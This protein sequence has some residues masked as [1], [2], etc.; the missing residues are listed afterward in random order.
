MSTT[1]VI[2]LICVF[3]LA[4]AVCWRFLNPVSVFHMLDHPNQRSLHKDPVPRSGGLAFVFVAFIGAI[5]LALTAEL[6]I[7]LSLYWVAGGVFL[8][9]VLGFLDD[10]SHVSAV[11]RLLAHFLA[12]GILLMAGWT[13]DVL[14]LPG[15]EVP[16]NSIFAMVFTVGF[17][18]WMINLYNFMDG[19]DGFAGGM[20]IVGFSTLAVLGFSGGDTD[21]TLMNLLVVAAVGGFLIWNFPPAKIFMGD[22]GSA[23]LGYMAA[24]M[25]LWGTNRG[26][27]PFWVALLIFSPFIVDASWTL[28]IRIFRGK[29]VWQAHKEHLYQRLVQVGWG[30]RKTV[31]TAYV[32]ML[33]CAVS[34]F[35][36]NQA[37]VLVQ[38]LGIVV[39]LTA[40][41]G[42]IMLVPVHENRNGLI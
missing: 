14:L 17:V 32:L 38:W 42:I 29:K 19:M 30:H 37:P 21:F 26:L 35:W 18:V 5:L 7:S 16:L 28:L 36:L 15:V 34:A 10:R 8:L 12:A 9:A 6:T 33:C 27:F 40:Y 13:P 25:S 4:A 39:W 3:F 22:A 20:A 41:A 23:V 11:V 24:V 31:I 2:L 1:A